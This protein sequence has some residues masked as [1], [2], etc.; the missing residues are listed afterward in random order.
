[1]CVR[2]VEPRRVQTLTPE[3]QRAVARF[4]DIVI[5]D[6]SSCA[7]KPSLR[8]V[9]PGRFT[10]IEPAAVEIHAT[11]RGF[12]DEVQTVQ[13]AP[14]RE[15]PTPQPRAGPSHRPPPRWINASGGH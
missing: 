10:T 14:D 8:E 9:F 15:R 11:S 7:L 6:G 13:I 3:G 5:Q 2:L 1:M 4:K 12:A